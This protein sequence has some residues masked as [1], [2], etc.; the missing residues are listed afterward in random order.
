MDRQYRKKLM[1]FS[2]YILTLEKK[3]S[4]KI[5]QFSK[6][7]WIFGKTAQLLLFMSNFQL[8]C[9]THI[10]LILETQDSQDVEKLRYICELLKSNRR[11]KKCFSRK[12][13]YYGKKIFFCPKNNKFQVISHYSI[14]MKEVFR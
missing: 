9:L 4:K 8:N 2:L 3:I 11:W 12:G 1:L 7:F 6:K 5:F 10:L 13:K 14:F